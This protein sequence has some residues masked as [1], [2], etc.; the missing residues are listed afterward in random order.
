MYFC[1]K[2]ESEFNQNQNLSIVKNLATILHLNFLDLMGN[3]MCMNHFLDLM[4]D[5]KFLD[6]MVDYEFL[7]ANSYVIYSFRFYFLY[8][9]Y[10]MEKKK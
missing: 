4:V 8:I 2:P 7:L 10:I 1:I 6:L 5:Y 3:L 9:F